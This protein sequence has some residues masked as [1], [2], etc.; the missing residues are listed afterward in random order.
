M[1]IIKNSDKE[2]LTCI[3]LIEPPVFANVEPEISALEVIHDQI[4]IFLILEGGLHV[5]NKGVLKV[6]KQGA[7]VQ[8]TVHTLFGN[9]QSLGHFLQG[10][11]LC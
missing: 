1:Q 8:D 11:D 6:R 5:D 7:F 2:I 3:G 10:I 9:D 4:K